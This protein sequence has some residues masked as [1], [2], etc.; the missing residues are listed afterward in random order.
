MSSPQVTA[1]LT[2]GAGGIG[3]AVAA[4]LLARGARLLLVDRDEQGLR[5]T[6]E[7]LRGHAENVSVLA[8][9]L[10]NPAERERVRGEATRWQGGVNVLIN[11]AGV[12]PFGWFDEQPWEQ[13]EL[14]LR[15]NLHAPMHL[16]HLLLPHLKRQPWAR[17]VNTGSVFGAIGYPGY[18]GYCS[19]KFAL[20]GFT[21]ALRREL[22][23]STVRVHYF[24]PRA[25]RTPINSS[26][27]ERM[28]KELGTAMDPPERVAREL[29]DLLESQR[30]EHTV[31]WPEK[32]FVRL[33]VL[34]PRLVDRSIQKQL[35]VI[36]RYAR[37]SA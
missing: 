25:T 33:N 27:V 26:T 11:N 28:N 30:A 5:T 29:C 10:G 4:E 7:G 8:A 37:P 34:L 6:L 16:C 24:A 31:G 19:T 22:A 2:G 14:A 35:P 17:I 18:A 15:I 13:L 1:L 3:R 12:N 20:R 32:L 21:E 36:A 23:Q 9:D